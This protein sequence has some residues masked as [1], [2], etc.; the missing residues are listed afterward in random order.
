MRTA[1]E[2][3]ET[4]YAQKDEPFGAAQSWYEQ[5]KR[6]VLLASL[7]SAQYRYAFEPAGGTGV[8]TREL[9]KRCDRLLMMDWSSTAVMRARG[10][11]RDHP[12]AAAAV[13]NLPEHWPVGQ[14]FDLIVISELLY[15]LDD[16]AITT[17]A[18]RSRE[19]L[20]DHGELALLHWRHPS[21]DYP[22]NGERA[23]RLFLSAWP[24]PQIR[25][26]HEEPDFMLLV[27]EATDVD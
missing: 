12:N 21:L 11:L 1:R 24:R 16:V 27:I 14:R 5:R 17:I 9:A 13:G 4:A 23:H 22:S 6:S 18:R 2:Y 7:R 26:R 19:S 3:F 10:L 20:I 8:L 25:V 15:Y